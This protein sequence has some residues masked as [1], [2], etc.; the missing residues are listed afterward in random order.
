[1]K[2]L[3]SL[4]L[5]TFSVLIA[6]ACGGGGGGGGGGD[7][8]PKIDS[9]FTLSFTK[10]KATISCYIQSSCQTDIRA[11]YVGKPPA[12]PFVIVAVDTKLITVSPSINDTYADLYISAFDLPAGEYK[13]LITV[14][15]CADQ[16]CNTRYG[17][18]YTIPYEFTVLRYFP[19][20]TTSIAGQSTGVGGSDIYIN[21][22]E[23]NATYELVIGMPH[24]ATEVIMPDEFTSAYK[25]EK[26]S[27]TRFNI[28]P[29]ISFSPKTYSFG[30]SG[31]LS[32][33]SSYDVKVWTTHS[34]VEMLKKNAP[35]LYYQVI[36]TQVSSPESILV[37]ANSNFNGE[38]YGATNILKSISYITGS[39][40]ATDSS[41]R[42][43][44][45]LTITPP[46]EY[47]IFEATVN[48]SYQDKIFSYPLILANSK[49]FQQ[50]LAFEQV[51][52]TPSSAITTAKF[53][54]IW[55]NC[56]PES[57]NF[58]VATAKPIS[59]WI[60]NVQY[61]QTQNKNNYYSYEVD[62]EKL[63]EVNPLSGGIP[64]GIIAL[65][66]TDASGNYAITR[67]DIN[68]KIPNVYYTGVKKANANAPFEQTIYGDLYFFAGVEIVKLEQDSNGQYTQEGNKFFHSVTQPDL[69]VD[70]LTFA[71]P[72]L[73][74]GM[75][76]LNF[77]GIFSK[78]YPE[79]L[80][81]IK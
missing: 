64:D 38:Y 33:S 68:L 8:E 71:M 22:S 69:P 35:P 14:D 52:V 3:Q 40:W 29:P 48:L 61:T 36:A 55:D 80:L 56:Y 74:A 44:L 37:E 49:T 78:H 63:G 34:V 31:P 5:I 65:S 50:A 20:F 54:H 59:N 18:R 42:W 58:Y 62:L 28:T 19:E 79:F 12:T 73:A 39:G 13:G 30:F 72:G 25:V 27:A 17:S 75:Y 51:E 1:M 9:S 70:S 2:V 6:T 10:T 23:S 76:K 11:N 4:L 45:G 41:S 7:P 67:I 81:E 15:V 66:S 24:T 53:E 43:T 26:I 16:N 47:G 77:S 57:C 60:K 32:Y 21:Y 46:A